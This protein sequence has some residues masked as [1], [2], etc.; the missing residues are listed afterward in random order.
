MF[1]CLTLWINYNTVKPCLSMENFL[2]LGFIL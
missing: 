2:F 1:A